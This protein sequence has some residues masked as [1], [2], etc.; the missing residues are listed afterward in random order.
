M[1]RSSQGIP[2]R[3]P[4]IIAGFSVLAA[5]L[6]PAAWASQ[7]VGTVAGMDGTAYVWRGEKAIPAA[8][9]TAV[10]I[11]DQL[12]T[13]KP[14]KLR[15]VFQDDSVLNVSDDSRV[16]VDDSVFEPAQGKAKSLFGLLQGKVN[17]AVSEY[18]RRSGNTYEIRTETAVAGVRGTEFAMTFDPQA[19]LTE[20]IGIEGVVQVHSLRDPEGDGVLV[21]ANE[22]TQV[23]RNQLPSE[24]SRLNERLFRDRIEGFD[25]IGRGR[26]EGL[27]SAVALASGSTVMRFGGDQKVV[28]Q[29]TGPGLEQ[30][31]T[32]NIGTQGDAASRLGQPISA[33]VLTGQLGLDLGR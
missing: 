12:A 3:L 22:T 5:I 30:G 24:P 14:G 32:K 31:G 23:G 6:A 20:V 13:G 7:E 29:G 1:K 8:I 4:T 33:L 2:S 25:F 15:V 21:T 9:G 17:A 18:Y 27:L 28:T 19:A 10:H 16:T 26:P 11:G